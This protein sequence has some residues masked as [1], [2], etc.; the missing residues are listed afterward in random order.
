MSTRYDTV[1]MSV[2]QI[3]VTSNRHYNHIATMPNRHLYRNQIFVNDVNSMSIQCRHDVITVSR[4]CIV[5][6]STRDD[7]VTISIRHTF[8]WHRIDIQLHRDDVVTISLRLKKLNR[9]YD[10]IATI[11]FKCFL[12]IYMY[13]CIFFLQLQIDIA[14][15][16]C[17]CF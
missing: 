9:C 3:V 2:R 8:W 16:S 5:S 6:M 7:T 10:C 17:R 14:A 13:V 11:S 15:I 4:N 1:T 12:D